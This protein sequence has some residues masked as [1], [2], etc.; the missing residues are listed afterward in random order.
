[1]TGSVSTPTPALPLPGGGSKSLGATAD[2]TARRPPEFP[3]PWAVAWGDDR[4]GLWA[5]LEVKTVIQRLR[6]IEPGEFWMGSD[7]AERALLRDEGWERWAK[8]ESPRHRVR[9]SEG[10]WLADTACTQAL[11]LVVVGGTNPSDFSSDPE[12]PV[13]QVSFDD[14]QGFLQRLQRA[15]TEGRQADLPTES[16]WEFACRAGNDTA[17]AFG[18]TVSPHQVN[19]NGDHPYG[20]AAK[21]L[22]RIHT[23]RVKALPPN[24][25]GLYQMHG[26]VWEWCD[27]ALRN[28]ADTAVADGFALDPAGLL[29]LG[30]TA[31]RALRGGSWISRAGGVRAAYRRDSSRGA[32][33]R[34]MGFRFA[35]MSTS[36]V[37]AEPGPEG[38]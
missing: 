26:N 16:Q 21:G 29:D 35:L 11:W 6:W 4:F 24:R 36:P 20:D 1:M 30:P 9:L 18:E 34:T 22:N 17:Y 13:E 33:R 5:D 2:D 27:D 37:L 15:H 7:E 28:Y 25:W 32:H 38:R 3:P 31:H 19:Y 10:F 12:L 8:N 23:V 14:V